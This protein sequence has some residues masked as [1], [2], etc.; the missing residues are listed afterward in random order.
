MAVYDLRGK[1]TADLIA[2]EDQDLRK[3]PN[4]TLHHPSDA[5]QLR[6]IH[7]SELSA[8]EPLLEEV[9]NGG[10]RVGEIFTIEQMR[11]RRRNDI[12]RLDTGVKRLV[13]PHIYHV[14]LTPELWTLKQDLIRKTLNGTV[15]E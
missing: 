4:L 7:A 3:P 8:M 2:Q 11:A 6:H 9:M 15:G 12:E 13:N 5:A 1:A 14:S 10:K